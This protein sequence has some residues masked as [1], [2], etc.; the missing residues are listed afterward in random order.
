MPDQNMR[1]PTS[2]P[3][4]YV[5]A[6]LLAVLTAPTSSEAQ[7]TKLGLE[8][9][10][11][12]VF[13]G[14]QYFP[15]VAKW[16]DRAYVVVWNGAVD[17]DTDALG[18]YGRLINRNGVTVGQDFRVNSTV[19]GNQGYPG[20][21]PLPGGGFVVAWQNDFSPTD[22]AYGIVAQRYDSDGIAI[23]GEFQVNAET[24]GD[25]RYLAIGGAAADG[26]FVVVWESNAGQAPDQTEII[27]RRFDSIGQ[28]LSSEFQVNTFTTDEQLL[29]AV[30]GTP[31]G[32]FVVVWQS[33][34]NSDGAGSGVRG[35]RFDSNGGRIGGE[36]EVNTYT[37]YN[38]GGAAVDSRPDGSFVVVWDAYRSQASNYEVFA[39][40]FGS[41]G[42]SL[43][44]EFQVNSETTNYQHAPSVRV[45]SDGTFLVLWSSDARLGLGRDDIKGQLYDKQGQLIGGEFQVN[46]TN[47]G[48]H[49]YP[50]AAEAG[51]RLLSVWQGRVP[52][53]SDGSGIGAQLYELPPLPVPSTS[54]AWLVVCGAIVI[55]ICARFRDALRLGGALKRVPAKARLPR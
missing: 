46:S 39:R 14:N 12:E 43:G 45:R 28:G 6:W 50:R 47:S 15:A 25:Q 32:S 8:F 49:F 24:L 44:D 48:A 10:V 34:G 51:G 16:R 55:A 26:S 2:R 30:S 33:Y 40:R 41:D 20:V 11:N 52:P 23:G 18:V 3:A 42:K 54:G 13:T 36:F 35:Q 29:P 7:L 19:T 38:E 17:Q 4:W 27:G 37:T 31:D 21:Q 9:A 53:D 22:E 1:V 5:G